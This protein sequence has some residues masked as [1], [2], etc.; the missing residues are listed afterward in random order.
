MAVDHECA[1]PAA[2]QQVMGQ[3][4]GPQDL[5]REGGQGMWALTVSRVL[6]FILII[7]TGQK[8]R[9]S[10]VFVGTNESVST[11]MLGPC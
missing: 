3:A 8:C 1:T 5:W 4:Q 7:G 6:P 10:L 2:G 9:R 11:Q